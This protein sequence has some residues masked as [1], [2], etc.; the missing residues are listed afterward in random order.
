MPYVKKRCPRC[1]ST[2]PSEALCCPSCGAEFSAE[3]EFSPFVGFSAK[4]ISAKRCPECAE[5]VRAEARKCRFCGYVF[6]TDAAV[7]DTTPS[8][9]EQ[10]ADQSG[11]QFSSIMIVVLLVLLLLAI[12]LWGGVLD[13]P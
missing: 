13:R 11:M 1:R 3:Q 12:V 7:E 2:V 5:E 6:S 4:L 10:K 8:S 9:P